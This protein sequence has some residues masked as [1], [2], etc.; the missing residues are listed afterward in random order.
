MRLVY[1][2]RSDRIEGYDLTFR[3]RHRRSESV[4][5]IVEFVSERILKVANE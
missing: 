1:G 3:T 2:T 4:V 5:S